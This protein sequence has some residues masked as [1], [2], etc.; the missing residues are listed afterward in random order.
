MTV[1][2]QNSKLHIDIAPE[3][4]DYVWNYIFDY[5]KDNSIFTS[6]FIDSKTDDAVKLFFVIYFSNSLGVSRFH[7][8]VTGLSKK[9]FDD[10]R[11]IL[12]GI[13]ILHTSENYKTLYINDKFVC[14]KSTSSYNIDNRINRITDNIVM[15][16]TEKISID[17]DIPKTVWGS[18]YKKA[19]L[20]YAKKYSH[21]VIT[22]EPEYSTFDS[23][24]KKDIKK[25]ID[26]AVEHSFDN[27]KPATNHIN[28][29]DLLSDMNNIYKS[30]RVNTGYPENDIMI[31]AKLA[32]TDARIADGRVY[33]PFHSVSR[34]I[35]ETSL[36]M[37][38]GDRF[39]EMFDIHNCQYTML[40]SLLDN[41]V[42]EYE[43]ELY[44]D[45]CLSGKF[46]ES[47]AEYIW[48]DGNFYREDAKRACAKYLNVTTK[49]IL[50]ARKRVD[51][52]LP[53]ANADV[54]EVDKY[55]EDKFRHIRN[56][57]IKTKGNGHNIL[58]L[59]LNKTETN[60]VT[61]HLVRILRE[62]YGMKTAVSLHDA[63]YCSAT[64]FMNI[65]GSVENYRYM[66]ANKNSHTTYFTIQKHNVQTLLISLLKG[67]IGAGIFLSRE[68]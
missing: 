52:K 65:P 19:L 39:I 62:K 4:H 31:N 10:A 41:S 53:A 34:D 32:N 9:A 67:L 6:K 55:F 8:S 37:N 66:P 61:F 45:L 33:H 20:Q 24:T 7:K 59:L 40:A 48:G 15:S 42:P 23:K 21:T 63:I 30:L 26:I 64:E 28:N 1:N 68:F 16:M 58:H 27:I 56:F 11:N 36:Y 17:A 2:I 51:M 46:Y 49:K 57:I 38:N 44:T 3:F 50:N 29:S 60:I 43:C 54:A 14:A 22:D 25:K 18:T 5:I 35:R 12:K 47:V 13:N